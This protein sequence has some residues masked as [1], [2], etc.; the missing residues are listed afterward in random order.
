MKFLGGRILR[1]YPAVWIC[2]TITLMFVI[3]NGVHDFGDV[4]P[5]YVHTLLL[6]P[7][8]T[9]FY[10][11]IDGV[12]WTLAIEISF[13]IMV[14][15]TLLFKNYFSVLK[16]GAV[17]T[18]FSVFYLSVS[19]ASH[20]FPEAVLVKN[21]AGFINDNNYVFNGLFI[22]R[23]GCLFSVG[24]YLFKLSDSGLD[25]KQKIILSVS[26]LCG[27]SEIFLRNINFIYA[28]NINLSPILPIVIWLFSV[29]F[30]F[31]FSRASFS[32]YTPHKPVLVA[33]RTMGLMTYPF[34]LL[35]DVV[36]TTILNELII[37]GINKYLSLLCVFVIIGLFSY[38]IS[39]KAEPVIRNALMVALSTFPRALWFSRTK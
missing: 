29:L 3:L 17:L 23:Y 34:Y 10:Q 2:A 5:S 20:Y 7:N 24:I 13:Y 32:N 11:W 19:I 8:N 25:A 9:Y 14:F 31:L 22:S 15:L 35:H 39:I 37:Y 30:I 36:G 21:V 4:F 33:L 26:I 16:L 18:L 27:A 28:T 12:Y 6:M 38:V 1:L